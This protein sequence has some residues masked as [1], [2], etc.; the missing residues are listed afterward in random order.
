MGITWFTYRDGMEQPLCDTNIRSDAGWGC[1]LR[2]GQMI[3][4]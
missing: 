2:T 4:I 3:V 1:M